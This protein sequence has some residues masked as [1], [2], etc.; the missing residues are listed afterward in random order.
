METKNNYGLTP[1]EQ[2]V[3]MAVRMF[4]RGSD[5]AVAITEGGVSDAAH[6]GYMTKPLVNLSLI[7]I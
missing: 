7:H 5:G 3:T 4:A 2:V 1:Y 6:T